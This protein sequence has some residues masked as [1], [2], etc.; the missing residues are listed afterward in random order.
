MYN[1]ALAY[2]LLNACH[3]RNAMHRPPH[4][5][6]HAHTCPLP[7]PLYHSHIYRLRLFAAGLQLALVRQL[8]VTV[9]WVC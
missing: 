9:R 5:Y 8:S 2:D 6:T 1:L 7:L 4:P 3:T